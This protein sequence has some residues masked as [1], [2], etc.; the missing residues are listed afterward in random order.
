MNIELKTLMVFP[1]H[2]LKGSRA[3]Y[4]RNVYDGLV[5]CVEEGVSR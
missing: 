3:V 2:Y 5:G 4:C 1:V